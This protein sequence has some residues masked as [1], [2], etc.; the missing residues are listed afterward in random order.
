MPEPRFALAAKIGKVWHIEHQGPPTEHVSAL[1]Y[2][3]RWCF[4]ASLHFAQVEYAPN[5]RSEGPLLS[6]CFAPNLF[7]SLNRNAIE[8]DNGGVNRI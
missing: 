4:E 8:F 3:F 6:L 2:C 1:A 7:E 5:G